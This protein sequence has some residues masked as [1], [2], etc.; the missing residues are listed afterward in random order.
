MLWI[1]PVSTRRQALQ[2]FTLSN[3]SKIETGEWVCT[4]AR[5]M[6]RDP[7]NYGSPLEFHGFRFLHPEQL[8]KLGCEVFKI[9]EPRKPSQLTEVADWQ[10]WGT[11]R[12]AW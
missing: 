7:A 4:P 10:I 3:G 1:P 9:P 11:G 8:K 6:M 2:P 5:A 12:M